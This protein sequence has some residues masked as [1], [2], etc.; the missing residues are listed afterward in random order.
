VTLL[1]DQA[2]GVLVSETDTSTDNG[3]VTTQQSDYTDLV[4]NAPLPATFPGAFPADVKVNRSGDPSLGPVPNPEAAAQRFGPGFVAPADLPAGSWI[5]VMEGPNASI[6]IR[7]GFVTSRIDLVAEPGRPPDATTPVGQP[8]L[9][10]GDLAG[11]GYELD[12]QGNLDM[13]R[14]TGSMYISAPSAEEALR[15]ANSLRRYS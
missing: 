15:I 11:T 6:I 9:T 8:T 1:I 2:T 7:H 3:V 14:G 10:D 13:V 4:V 5:Q 12:D